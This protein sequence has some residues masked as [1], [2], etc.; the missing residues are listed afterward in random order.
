MTD[1]AVIFIR[2]QPIRFYIRMSIKIIRFA[3]VYNVFLVERIRLFDNIDNKRA[4]IKL[5]INLLSVID[6]K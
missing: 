2:L 1:L 3:S 4:E 6:N 5:N